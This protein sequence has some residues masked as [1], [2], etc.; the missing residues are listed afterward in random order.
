MIA[1]VD[2]N[3]FYASCERVFD[4]SL[5]G[6]P[7]VVMSNNDGC[8]IARSEEAKALGIEM[9]LPV[10]DLNRRF[11]R[12]NVE[13]YSSNYTL[14]GSMSQR[15]MRILRNFVPEVETYSIDEAFLDFSAVP[16]GEQEELAKNIRAT[17]LSHTGLPVSIGIAPTKALAKMANRY[18]KKHC[19]QV[20]VKLAATSAEIDC[21]LQDT[22]IGD[23]WG[24]GRQYQQLLKGK[25]V[26]TAADFVR[27][28]D[29]WVRQHM[30]VMTERLLYELRG[31]KAFRWE[32]VLP[33]R[34]NI[35]SSRA[36]H[37][38]LTR[39]EELKAPIAS[40]AAA[41]ARKLRAEHS[42]AQ[43]VYVFLQTNPFQARDKQYAGTVTIPLTVPTSSSQE[44]V[45]F[46]MKGLYKIFRPGY[47]Y[48][49]CGVMLLD[50]IPDQHVQL[51]LF[52]QR[53][54][55]RENRLMNSLDKTNARFGKDV[56]RYAAQGYGKHWHLRASRLSPRY[57]THVD[58][59]M[60]VK[61]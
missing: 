33:C 53:D 19:R 1:L 34:K 26:K 52:D 61:S 41:C 15:V 54:R 38:R 46:A 21:L 50:L 31:I 42:L 22:E 4:P 9:G 47:K 2:I 24:I 28:P 29:D 49:K 30:T 39:L 17:I 58:E 20:G 8:V 45:K 56:V 7:I 40:H 18:A 44:I 27:L 51:S 55:Q 3:N 59:I 36:F 35:R 5:N 11:S 14:Y 60:I 25:G 16:S 6:K 57:T 43:A 48:Q 10:A 13:V 23:V 37:E 32:E 12:A